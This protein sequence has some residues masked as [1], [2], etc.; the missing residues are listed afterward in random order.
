MQRTVSS[1][2]SGAREVSGRP[3]PALRY[4]IDVA[5]GIVFVDLLNVRYPGAV[6]AALRAIQDDPA[7]RQDFGILVEC[8]YLVSPTA[9]GIRELAR[10]CFRDR[11]ELAGAVAVVAAGQAVNAGARFFAMLTAAPRDRLRVFEVFGEAHAWL[12][13]RCFNAR[14]MRQSTPQ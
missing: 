7:Y 10:A 3:R 8:G 12:C 9:E 2:H 13:L 5:A 1:P 6:V 4:T 14:S 11:A